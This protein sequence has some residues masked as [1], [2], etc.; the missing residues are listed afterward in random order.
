MSLV[1]LLRE[2]RGGVRQD[3]AIVARR[4]HSRIRDAGVRQ[5][6]AIVA[7]RPHSRIRGAGVRERVALLIKKLRIFS[8]IRG[9]AI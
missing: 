6:C 1:D 7:R 8:I 2:A 4:P 3:C 9:N 5:D